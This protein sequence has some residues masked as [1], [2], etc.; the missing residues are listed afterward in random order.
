[1]E[2]NNNNK[3]MQELNTMFNTCL[4]ILKND[5]GSLIID[6]VLEEL[7]RFIILKQI[8]K[9]ILNGSIDIY[10]L[11]YYPEGII[12]YGEEKFIE[13]LEYVKFSKFLEY[14]NNTEKEGNIKNVFD[15]FIWKEVL[16]KHQ[17]FKDVFQEG[18]KSYIIESKTIKKI[19][20]TLGE[21]D[22]EKYDINELGES[23]GSIFLDNVYGLGKHKRSELIFSSTPKVKKLLVSLVD[24][25]VNE[26]GEI[27][28]V[29]DP[30]AG[31]GGILNTVIKHYS[32]KIHDKENLRKQ[33]VDKIYGIEINNKIFNL[34]MSNMLINTGEILPKVICSDAIRNFQNI[35]V[36]TIIDSPSFSVTIK[37]EDLLS[38]L[39]SV[40]ILNDYIPIKASNSNSEMLFLQMMIHCLNIN[41]RCATVLLYGQKIYGTSSGYDK[42]REYLMRSCELH[43]VIL[44][45]NGTFP[46]APSKTCILFFTKK[47]E[48]SEVL[49]IYGNKRTLKFIDE[50]I[51]ATENVKFYNFIQESGEKEFIKEVSIEEI[52]KKKYSLNHIDYQ[53]KEE[54]KDIGNIKWKELGEICNFLQKSKRPASYGNKSGKYPFFKSSTKVDSYVEEPDYNIESLIIG[55]GGESNINHGTLFSCSDHCFILQNKDIS[56][57]NLKF[58][59][60]YI[61][62][63][64]NKLSELYI[65]S[66]MKNISKSS[67][68]S[69]KIPLISLEK[70]NEIVRYLDFLEAET[71]EMNKFVETYNSA[72]NNYIGLFEMTMR[73]NQWKKLI[74]V[75]EFKNG[76]SIK[77]DD[78][79]EGEYPVIGGGKKPLGYHK[80]YNR[81]ENTI[82]CASSGCSGYISRYENKVWASGC[83]S[84]H[85]KNTKVLNEL[86]L[87]YYLIYIQDNIYSMA[88]GAARLHVSSKDIE[89]IKI[90]IP[91]LEKQQEVID[92]I[93]SKNNLIKNTEKIIESNKTM[94]YSR[95]EDILNTFYEEEIKDIEESEYSNIPKQPTKKLKLKVKKQ[96]I[97]SDED[98]ISVSESSSSPSCKHV[99]RD[100]R[101]CE[102]LPKKNP[103]YCS[104]HCK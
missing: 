43:E 40:E 8:E 46:C 59:Y 102:T 61:Y 80:E 47:K 67:L 31:T 58:V 18:K 24:P 36:D 48:R 14:V 7:S 12:D 65:G 22:F 5:N 45:P 41:G 10:N 96:E 50:N 98:S 19:F 56:N 21:I 28:S 104:K 42:V 3:K 52:A 68:E 55:D 93:E 26:K 79:I 63:N 35:K 54:K 34:C 33:L 69:F 92:S 11:E 86:Y 100:G 27:E 16:S 25:K 13:N 20:I 29:L 74:E 66:A 87:Y 76:K 103:K 75:C 77:K 73:Q 64:L 70:Q 95:L 9:H 90:P 60:Y 2:N 62:F 85:S 89:N 83:F 30:S 17:M 81:D 53:I 91:S 37:Y 39:G 32:S 78:L 84:I 97:S 4:D 44:C 82:L 51:H 57:T 1:M 88:K 6:E 101:K 38:S 99:Y 72:K 15:N 71:I 49:E 23:Y 94:A